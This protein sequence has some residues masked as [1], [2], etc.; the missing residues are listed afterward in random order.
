LGILYDLYIFYLFLKSFKDNLKIMSNN[1]NI[2]SVLIHVF[3][4][5]YLEEKYKTENIFIYPGSINDESYI[6][7]FSNLLQL[8]TKNKYPLNTKL[9]LIFIPMDYEFD[10]DKLLDIKFFN[11]LKN[12]ILNIGDD[13]RF[14]LFEL[15]YNNPLFK[16]EDINNVLSKLLSINETN[17]IEKEI[18][19][20]NTKY[21]EF[22]KEEY[23]I[24][25]NNFR[26]LDLEIITPN[27]LEKYSIRFSDVL[28]Y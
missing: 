27:E 12:M 14:K 15:A 18:A 22:T 3:V 23:E 19:K 25:M 21:V 1:R 17:G 6:F 13:N 11:K 9:L 4:Q 24:F 28:S 8:L 16:K 20:L 10:D 26:N 7:N 5:M 2:K